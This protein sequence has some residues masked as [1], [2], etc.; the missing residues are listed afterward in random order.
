VHRAQ[1]HEEERQERERRRR[2]NIPISRW[3]ADFFEIYNSI[4]IY[5]EEGEYAM[6][7]RDDEYEGS[8]RNT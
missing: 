2:E 1:L 8:Y 3:L 7:F 5:E 6:S 4:V